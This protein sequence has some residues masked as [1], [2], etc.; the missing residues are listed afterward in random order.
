M[1]EIPGA[2]DQ[3][4]TGGV[5]CLIRNLYRRWLVVPHQMQKLTDRATTQLGAGWDSGLALLRS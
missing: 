2:Y 3:N 1:P 5:I 4:L